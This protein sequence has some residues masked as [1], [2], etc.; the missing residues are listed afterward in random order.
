MKEEILIV[1]HCG[2]CGRKGGCSGHE[3]EGVDE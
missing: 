1:R 2:V 3:V